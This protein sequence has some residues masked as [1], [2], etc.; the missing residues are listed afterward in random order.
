MFL[1]RSIATF[2][3]AAHLLATPAQAPLTG[4]DAAALESWLVAVEDYM[5]VREQAARTIPVPAVA[6]DAR[7]VNDARV[8][9][10]A[11]IRIRRPGAKIGDL[12]TFEI[13]RTFRKL[14]AH[15]LVGHGIVPGDLL[16][17]LRRQIGPGS[18]R[19]AVNE[20]Y[21]WQLRAAIPPCVLDVLPPLPWE[22]DWRVIDH[23]L[24]LIDLGSG[25]VVD[26]LPDAFPRAASLE[27]N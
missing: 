2:G 21:P 14:I 26:V 12:F 19:I 24:L 15:S 22:L 5:V 7:Q 27:R 13:R 23:D 17:E 20:P 1:T 4:K 25:L 6:P 11:A 10:A 3:F 9:L 8:A 18:Y 16:A